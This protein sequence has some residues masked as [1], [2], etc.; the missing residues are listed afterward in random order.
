MECVVDATLRDHARRG[1]AALPGGAE[2]RP[3]DPVDGELDVG[4]VENDDRVLASELEVD[5]RERV[6]R[7]LQ[8]LDAR[9][10]GAGQRDHACVR[11]AHKPFT[12]R[13]AA[14]VDDVHDSARNP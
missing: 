13:A 11:M 4:V 6:G 10:A 5:V 2:R 9:L 8:H 3:E 1:R 12:D 14:A 7:G